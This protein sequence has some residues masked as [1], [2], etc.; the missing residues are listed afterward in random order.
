M[1]SF[2]T[3]A[4]KKFGLPWFFQ[5]VVYADLKK[6]LLTF[7]EILHNNFYWEWLSIGI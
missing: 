1:T 2:I 4:Y 6:Y 7:P 3:L 5:K